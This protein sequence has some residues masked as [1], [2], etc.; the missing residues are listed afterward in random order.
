M[1]DDA[2]VAAR[3]PTT[4]TRVPTEQEFNSTSGSFTPRMSG[5]ALLSRD[6]SLYATHDSDGELSEDIE[7]QPAS[8]K[9]ASSSAK[10]PVARSS[11]LDSIGLPY[12]DAIEE[13][14]Q[15]L[16]NLADT[17]VE[18]YADIKQESQPDSARN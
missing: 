17:V 9:G 11:G 4:P 15:L 2:E 3:A 6:E 7:Y 13:A 1:A 8:S 16:R 18:K 10:A 14:L 5:K 12:E